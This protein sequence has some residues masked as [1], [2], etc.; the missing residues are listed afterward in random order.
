[1][2]QGRVPV[3]LNGVVAAPNEYVLEIGPLV[4]LL[5]LQEEENLVLFLAPGGL[6]EQRVQLIVPA[7]ATLLPSAIG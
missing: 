5:L 1:M 3:V 4:L 7:L 6:L 2:L